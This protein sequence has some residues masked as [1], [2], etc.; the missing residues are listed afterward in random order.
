MFIVKCSQC[1]DQN[2][3]EDDDNLSI[4]LYFH[5]GTPN[6]MDRM[7]FFCGNCGQ[8]EERGI[9]WPLDINNG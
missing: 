3:I 4:K 5:R 2:P 8:K 1:G 9:S 7:V 6:T